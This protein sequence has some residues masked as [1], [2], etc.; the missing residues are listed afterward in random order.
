MGR[1]DVNISPPIFVSFCHIVAPAPWSHSELT[2]A[3]FRISCSV[4]TGVSIMVICVIEMALTWGSEEQSA[5]GKKNLVL[6]FCSQS[7][8]WDA[9]VYILVIAFS[10]GLVE[11]VRRGCCL[12]ER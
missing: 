8:T 3:A 12:C 10:Y 1:Q 11:L 9:V 6:N 2:F 7:H 4:C 5:C